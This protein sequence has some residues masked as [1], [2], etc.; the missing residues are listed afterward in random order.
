MVIDCIFHH[1]KSI[2]NFIVDKD[3]HNHTRDES[4]KADFDIGDFIKLQFYFW[5]SAGIRVSQDEDSEGNLE[6]PYRKSLTRIGVF[7]YSHS[8]FYF[9]D[10]FLPLY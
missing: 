2:L 4:S 10:T 7:V 5:I 6:E 1:C 9:S 3:V 8:P